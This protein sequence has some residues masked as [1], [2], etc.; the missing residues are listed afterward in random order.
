MSGPPRFS[1][2]ALRLAASARL[3]RLTLRRAGRACV[4]VPIV[5]AACVA[6]PSAAAASVLV[7]AGTDGVAGPIVAGADGAMWFLGSTMVER[8]TTRGRIR[9]FRVSGD[10]NLFDLVTGPDGNVWVSDSGNSSID[11]VTPAGVTTRFAM[12]HRAIP[13]AIASGP[14][15]DVWVVDEDAEAILRVAP[16]GQLRSYPVGVL[17]AAITGG[18]DGNVWFTTYG[19]AGGAA[20]YRLTPGGALTRF[21]RPGAD[22][23]NSIVTGPDGNL[24]LAEGVIRGPDRIARMAPDG[25]ATDFTMPGDV[26]PGELGAGPGGQ[27]WFTEAGRGDIAS[28]ATTGGAVAQHPLPVCGVPADGIAAAPDGAVWFTSGYL[29]AVGRLDPS[30]APGPC[31]PYVPHCRG[32]A[33]LTRHGAVAFHWSCS[34]A[35]PR[36]RIT[37]NRRLRSVVDSVGVF[38]CERAGARAFDCTDVHSEQDIAA[39][40]G[41]LLVRGA[42]CGARRLVLHVTAYFLPSVVNLR[43]L[44]FRL[45]GPC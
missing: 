30:A 3:R 29:G 17:P 10:P 16:S 28:M 34:D 32:R 5:L 26:T 40:E 42:A 38:G 21:A 8:V 24:W 35:S 19:S 33:K 11:R 13:R 6:T 43:P 25:T 41:R 44:R 36:F 37:A 45:S 18:P 15:G 14:G 31:R 12:P 22:V 23:L 27:I 2:R 20:V 9:R 1:H 7:H 39:G 4:A